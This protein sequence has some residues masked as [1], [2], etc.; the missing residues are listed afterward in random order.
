MNELYTSQMHLKRIL[1]GLASPSLT[2]LPPSAE[3]LIDPAFVPGLGAL[4]EDPRGRLQ[5]PIRGCG[6]WFEQLGP[7]IARAHRSVGTEKVKKALGIP[8]STGLV[9]SQMR[10]K[11][12]AAAKRAVASSL[13]RREGLDR[14]GRGNAGRVHV[15]RRITIHQKNHSDT[16]PAQLQDKITIL[17]RKLGRSPTLN[18]FIGQYGEQAAHEVRN[19]F[20]TWNN[21]K[22]VCGLSLYSAA[23]GSRL[24][25]K[26]RDAVLLSLKTWYD[27]HGDLPSVSDCENPSRAPRIPGYRVIMRALSVENWLAAMRTAAAHFGLSSERYGNRVA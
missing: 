15:A 11:M 16:C 7:H 1:S 19:V 26:T 13:S 8:K 18:E 24:H 3:K 6:K 25:A 22:A 17:D 20:G 21:A 2:P 27:E 10:T 23:D 4:N 12:R 5:C 14:G 9:A